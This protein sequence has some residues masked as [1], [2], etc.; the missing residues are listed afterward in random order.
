MHAGGVTLK[1]TYADMK[2]ITRSRLVISAD[3]AAVIYQ[4]ASRLLGQVEHDPV[5]LIGAGVYNLSPDS[6][7]QMVLD[8]FMEDKA[9][10]RRKLIERRLDEMQVRYGLDFAGNLEKIYTGETLHRTV[11]YMRKHFTA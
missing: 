11:E 8:D 1:L 2:N 5:R 6:G 10:E 3:S 9:E 7:R 4:E